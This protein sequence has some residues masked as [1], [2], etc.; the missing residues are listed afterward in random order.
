[1][2]SVS[3]HGVQNVT[4][5]VVV[6]SHFSTLH[7][8]WEVD[9]VTSEVTLFFEDEAEAVKAVKAIGKAKIDRDDI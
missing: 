9:G 4:S 2:F 7:I 3:A 1:M 5:K 6:F 8:S